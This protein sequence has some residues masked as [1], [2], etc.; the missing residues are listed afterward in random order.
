MGPVTLRRTLTGSAGLALGLTLA[1][2]APSVDVVEPTPTFSS[3]A[4]AFAAA[5]RT[6]L[7][8]VDALN[9]VD[10]SDPETFEAVYAWTTGELN[11]ADRT[12][13][14]TYHAD[15]VTVSGESVVASM[16]GVEAFGEVKLAVCL[17]V[18]AVMLTDANGASLVESDRTG[19]QQLVVSLTRDPDSP[20]GLLIEGIGPRDKGPTCES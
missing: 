5:E 2:C 8:Y 11:S 7:E 6:Y 10:L 19:T 1:A 13:L 17:D 12:G 16:E 3:E 4:E 14:S 20:T 15:R 9:Q 18:S